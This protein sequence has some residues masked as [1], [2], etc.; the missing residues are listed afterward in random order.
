MEPQFLVFLSPQTRTVNI[1]VQGVWRLTQSV[2][3]S[4]TIFTQKPMNWMLCHATMLFP[5]FFIQCIYIS[6]HVMDLYLFTSHTFNQ[7]ENFKMLLITVH[8]G[9][10]W[11]RKYTRPDLDSTLTRKSSSEMEIVYWTDVKVQLAHDVSLHF[12]HYC[13]STLGFFPAT[14]VDSLNCIPI[15][16]NSPLESW[17][18]HLR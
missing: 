13:S 16:I 6:H 14:S 4:I 5:I 3:L 10:I 2:N 8:H 7:K 1:M 18:N 12:C 11:Y 9:T 15:E 17:I